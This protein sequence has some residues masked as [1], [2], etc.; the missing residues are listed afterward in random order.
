MAEKKFKQVCH[1]ENCGSEAEMIISCELL[2]EEAELE[3]KNVKVSSKKIEGGAQGH[4]VCQ[5]CGAE[6]DIWLD[7]GA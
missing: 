5:H 6:A 3:E 4:S 2:P 7:M 1:C